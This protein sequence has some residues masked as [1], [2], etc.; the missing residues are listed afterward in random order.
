MRVLLTGTTGQLGTAIAKEFGA[1][2]ELLLRGRDVLDITRHDEVMRQ[3]GACRPDVV[4]NCAGYND[5]DGA[6]EQVFHALEVNAFAVRSLARAAAD[7]GALFVHYSTD[8]VFNGAADRPYAEDDPTNPRSFY[9]ISKLLGEWFTTELPRSYVLRVESLF[10]GSTLGSAR[11]SSVDRIADAILDGREAVVFS[12]RTVSP[13]FVID[14]AAATRRLVETAPPFGLYHCVNS[15][16]CTWLELAR[17]LARL[18]DVQPKLVP[19]LMD[20]VPLPAA[21]PRYCAL[22]N[23]KLAAAGITMPT[24]QDALRR[25]VEMRA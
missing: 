17:E 19:R 25:Y 11:K 4:I 5:V 8:F 16:H 1:A 15:G 24:W 9:S 20:E 13:S 3:V 12:D 18:L 14:V 6:Q 23:R 7:A 10:G 21:R 22:D 2:H